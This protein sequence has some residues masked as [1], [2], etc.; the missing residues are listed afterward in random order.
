MYEMYQKLK[1][2]SIQ[3]M[4]HKG[5]IS[6]DFIEIDLNLSPQVLR[7]SS[8]E[9]ASPLCRLFQLHVHVCFSHGVFPSQWKTA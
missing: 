1:Q 8:T 4:H 2:I 5:L 9:L 6:L 3:I 7:E